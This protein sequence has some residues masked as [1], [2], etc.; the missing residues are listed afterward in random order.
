ME[1]STP[2]VRGSAIAQTQTE[3]LDGEAGLF[4]AS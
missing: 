2:G 1:P 3:P 4:Q